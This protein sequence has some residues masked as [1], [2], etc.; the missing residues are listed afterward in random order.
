MRRIILYPRISQSQLLSDSLVAYYALDGNAS[1]SHVNGYN[2]T[3][4]NMLWASGIINQAANFENTAAARYIRVPNQT[5]F[6][7]TNGSQD[8]PFTISTWVYFLGFSS[9]G[10]WL[11]NKRDVS[12]VPE[13]QF[14]RQSATGQIRMALF[15]Q[16]SNTAALTIASDAGYNTLNEWLHIVFVYDGTNYILYLNGVAQTGI[17]NTDTGYSAMGF[18]N[19]QVTLGAAGWQV[20]AQQTKHRGYIDETAIYKGQGATP[21]QV[22]SLYNGGAGL[23]YS[24]T[25]LI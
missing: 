18:T 25:L 7:F 22:L 24:Q 20:S 14:F 5:D 23:N 13:W 8:I 19:S 10:N 15:N 12:T 6:S 11:I 4:T 2:G 1:D 17:N 9:T 3:L 21:A 16:A